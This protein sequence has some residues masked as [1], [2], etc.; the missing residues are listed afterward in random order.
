V[1]AEDSLTEHVVEE[2]ILH[3]ELL[4]RLVVGG[5]NGE[6]RVNGGQFDNRAESLI[7]VHTGALC[8][9][10]KY[11]ASLVAVKSPIKERLVC[12][13][14]FVGDDVGATRLR[15]KF[16]DPI[17]HQGSILFLHSRTPI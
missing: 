16:L 17:A 5:N 13:Y 2:G 7:V 6:H 11:L 14:P 9:T 1:A 10:L 15:N 12:E 8:K 3:I 4:N